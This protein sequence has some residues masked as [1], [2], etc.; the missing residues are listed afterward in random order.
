MSGGGSPRGEGRNSPGQ[1]NA[2]Q[3]VRLCRGC[4]CE[5]GVEEL[6]GDDLE[7]PGSYAAYLAQQA[8]EDRGRAEEEAIEP[9]GDGH[10]SS[11]FEAFLT[12]PHGSPEKEPLEEDFASFLA[13]RQQVITNNVVDHPQWRQQRRPLGGEVVRSVEHADVDVLEVARDLES[14]EEQEGGLFRS[15][16]QS[17]SKIKDL[18]K[19]L[20]MDGLNSFTVDEGEMAAEDKRHEAVK[21]Q[22]MTQMQEDMAEMSRKMRDAVLKSQKLIQSSDEYIERET[23]RI[24]RGAAKDGAGGGYSQMAPQARRQARGGEGLAGGP[25]RLPGGPRTTTSGPGSKTARAVPPKER[26]GPPRAQSN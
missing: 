2:V 8:R 16:L 25:H 23:R 24:E 9:G 11:R 10:F 26:P 21:A 3:P 18:R 12:A 15:L 4:A 13:P 6:A 19:Q 7:P 22:R 14:D 1:Q 17:S 5:A 20:E